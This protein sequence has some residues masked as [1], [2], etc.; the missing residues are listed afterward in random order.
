MIKEPCK[1]TISRQDTFD[2]MRSLTKWSV[3]SVDGKFSNVGLLYDDVM[4]GIG[5][6][7]PVGSQDKLDEITY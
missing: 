6:L 3:L 4:F 1:D 7:H 2:L 5:S